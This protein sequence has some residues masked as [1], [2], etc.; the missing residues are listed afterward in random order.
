VKAN[1]ELDMGIRTCQLCPLWETRGYAV[2]ATVG[3]RYQ[4][5]GIALMFDYPRVEDDRTGQ[6]A[7]G[8]MGGLLDTLLARV[9][10]ARAELVMLNRVRCMPPRG[11]IQDH[12][13][14]VSNCDEAWSTRELAVYNPGIV[15]TMGAMVGQA[16]FGKE[17]KVTRDRGVLRA[18]GPK[19]Q[20]SQRTYLGTFHP[21]AAF[22]SGGVDGDV[23]QYIVEDLRSAKEVLS[24]GITPF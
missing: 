24:Y 11:R 18:T 14:A 10:L 19:H 4:P 2:P 17:F 5:G 13:D 22:Q 1:A 15:V 6:A 21:A 9:P 12:P 16:I 3:A 20:W 23:A 8:K 7:V